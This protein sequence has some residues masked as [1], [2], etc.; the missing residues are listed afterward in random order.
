MINF[1][2]EKDCV[3]AKL[4]YNISAEITAHKY[5]PCKSFAS[6]VPLDEPKVDY[7][8]VS[9]NN[10]SAGKYRTQLAA[11]LGL[12]KALHGIADSIRNS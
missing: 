10:Y 9:I 5:T 4:P 3:Y 7:F 11:M 2:E 12:S 6:V 1:K 8:Q